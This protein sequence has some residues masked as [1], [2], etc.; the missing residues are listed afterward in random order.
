MENQLG[1][2]I[3]GGSH[4]V[5]SQDSLGFSLSSLNQ[6]VHQII[7]LSC[8][9]I[10]THNETFLCVGKR[11]GRIPL[12]EGRAYS[13]VCLSVCYP[14][15][16]K[17]ACLVPFSGIS[18]LTGPKQNPRSQTLHSWI[19]SSPSLPNST[20]ASSA[21]S[22][23]LMVT[24]GKSS[25][26]LPFPS[27]SNQRPKCIPSTHLPPFPSVPSPT[28]TTFFPFFFLSSAEASYPWC[29]S[30][31][32][33]LLTSLLS[34]HS[35]FSPAPQPKSSF[36]IMSWIML[37][38]YLKLSSGF[39]WL[40]GRSKPLDNLSSIVLCHLLACHSPPCSLYS[41]PTDFPSF[42]LPSVILP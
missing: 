3:V 4:A 16:Q 11:K 9:K 25:L 34:L 6:S 7:A 31:L 42:R 32:T 39:L 15:P 19:H 18:V 20:I 36:S 28:Y 33:S 26:S 13:G 10:Q 29:S 23:C 41:S 40:L 38:S 17:V 2:T 5:I 14:E 30:H 12:V 35:V 22:K 8:F 21:F 27:I 24:P 37:V 1:L